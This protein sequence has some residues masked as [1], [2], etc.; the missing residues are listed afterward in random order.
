MTVSE[1]VLFASALR[2]EIWD[3]PFRLLYEQ[4]WGLKTR[5][6]LGLDYCRTMLR[7]A[8]GEKQTLFIGDSSSTVVRRRFKTVLRRLSLLGPFS[9]ITG[10][11]SKERK[12]A[13]WR[14]YERN[15]CFTRQ[16]KPQEIAV[17]LFFFHMAF[18]MVFFMFSMT[19]LLTSWLK[20]NAV[21]VTVLQE[22]LFSGLSMIHTQILLLFRPDKYHFKLP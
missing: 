8:P 1:P 9:K 13:R 2:L 18:S 15:Y 5:K 4:R 21:L 20:Q 7:S 3:L 12:E 6:S 16:I 19:S 14:K 11:K 10:Y 17:A 22:H